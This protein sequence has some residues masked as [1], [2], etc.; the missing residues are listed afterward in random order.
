MGDTYA[1]SSHGRIIVGQWSH[2]TTE[3]FTPTSA[4]RSLLCLLQTQSAPPWSTP[5]LN[6]HRFSTGRSLPCYTDNALLQAFTTRLYT[7]PSP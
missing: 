5:S 3:H 2:V 1:A 4:L 7:Q 6:A